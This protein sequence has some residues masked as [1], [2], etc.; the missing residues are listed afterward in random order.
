MW[1]VMEEW[2]W[3]TGKGGGRQSNKYWENENL[4]KSEM[5][6]GEEGQE[7]PACVN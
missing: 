3:E 6:G 5:G 2:G 7:T 4:R 1:E